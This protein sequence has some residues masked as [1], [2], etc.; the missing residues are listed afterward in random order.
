MGYI[1]SGQLGMMLKRMKN[2]VESS[3]NAEIM[4]R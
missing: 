3:Y 2:R 1:K 4:S